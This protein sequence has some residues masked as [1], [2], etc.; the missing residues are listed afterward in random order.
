MDGM[1]TFS[2]KKKHSNYHGNGQYSHSY[3]NI[4]STSSTEVNGTMDGNS[5]I[6]DNLIIKLQNWKKCI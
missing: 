4:A 3:N 2:P 6:N 5:S 1:I